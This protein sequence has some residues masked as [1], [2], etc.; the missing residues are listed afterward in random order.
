MDFLLKEGILHLT[1]EKFADE[2][3]KP[4][5]Q[6]FKKG[7]YKGLKTENRKQQNKFYL[8]KERNIIFPLPSKC[9][10]YFLFI[11]I[12]RHEAPVERLIN[13]LWKCFPTGVPTMHIS[14]YS[15]HKQ[16]FSSS[17]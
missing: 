17:S 13:N 8:V 1:K 6:Y 11:Y 10:S 15:P 2:E 9:C 16:A 14:I 3:K 12:F 7:I 5:E 4:N